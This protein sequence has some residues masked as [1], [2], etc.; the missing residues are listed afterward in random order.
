M[1]TTRGRED[2]PFSQ[3]IRAGRSRVARNFRT[4]SYV[5]RGFYGQQIRA[6]LDLFPAG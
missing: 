5:G 1:E 6:M 3:A 2:L 4:F